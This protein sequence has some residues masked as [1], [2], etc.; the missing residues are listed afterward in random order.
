MLG[1]GSPALSSLH[2]L[3]AGISFFRSCEGARRGSRCP[4]TSIIPIEY[5]L[6]STFM[7]RKLTL[8]SEHTTGNTVPLTLRQTALEDDCR[9][10][11]ELNR[12]EMG[13]E[14]G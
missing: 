10:K 1:L 3:A 11:Q 9:I 12:D 5:I 14:R 13:I 6:M 7:V 2:R 8:I 4:T